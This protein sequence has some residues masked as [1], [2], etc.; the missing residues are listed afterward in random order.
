MTVIDDITVDELVD[1]PYPVYARL[2]SEAP[3]CWVPS[4]GL[5]FVSRWADV[6]AAAND[7]VAFP[8]ATPASPLD[9]TLGGRS[10]LT[11]GARLQPSAAS[12]RGCRPAGG[13]G[14]RR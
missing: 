8:A 13:V 9:R 1:D 6:E 4:V 14:D 2:R 11:G 12:G 7:P 5:W 3:V 10:I